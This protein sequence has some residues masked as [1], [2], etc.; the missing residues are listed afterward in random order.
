MQ[1]MR[2]LFHLTHLLSMQVL[3]QIGFDSQLGGD[4]GQQGQPFDAPLEQLRPSMAD[5]LATDIFGGPVPDMA[6]SSLTSFTHTTM[7]SYFDSSLYIGPG[8][9]WDAPHDYAPLDQNDH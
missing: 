7:P 1:A 6:S 5:Q 8:S 9:H 2:T 4:L 3:T